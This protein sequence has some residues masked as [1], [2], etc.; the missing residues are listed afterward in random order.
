MRLS[1]TGWQSSAAHCTMALLSSPFPE[2]SHL[3]GR[4]IKI[5]TRKHGQ[6]HEK[7]EAGVRSAMGPQEE[8][9]AK[10]IPTSTPSPLCILGE[11]HRRQGQSKVDCQ[12]GGRCQ[13]GTWVPVP[14]PT[15]ELEPAAATA[16][17]A[18]RLPA[19][20]KPS[21]ADAFPCL[22][23]S[24][25]LACNLNSPPCK[26]HTRAGQSQSPNGA[27]VPPGKPWAP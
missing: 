2:H 6:K 7:T 26:T 23:R 18:F 14:A 3:Q 13:A 10:P 8:S 4:R 5:H 27:P 20:V 9:I 25:G 15:A 19:L 22:P 24:P 16:G 12:R 17:T 11:I 21:W 1:G